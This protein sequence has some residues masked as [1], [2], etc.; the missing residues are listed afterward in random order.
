MEN[1]IE[2]ISRKTKSLD[3]LS[4]YKSRVSK[5]GHSK[6]GEFRVQD[7]GENKDEKKKKKKKKK[8]KIVKEVALDSLEPVVKKIR[9]SL[10]EGHVNDTQSGSVSVDSGLSLSGL[11]QKN[12]LNGLS[13][14]LCLGGPG[15]VIHIPKRPRGSVRRKKV[16]GNGQ[17][18]ISGPSDSVDMA[19]KSNGETRKA[20]FSGSSGGEAGSDD[21][22]AKLLSYSGSNARGSKVKR[23]RIVDKVKDSRNGTS[24]RHA[25]EEGGHVGTSNG[26]TSS[27]KHR[28]NHRKRKDLGSGSETAQKRNVDEVKYS[29][30]DTPSQHAKEEGG[31]V[32]VING[33]SSSKKRRSNDRKRKDLGSGSETAQKT[34]ADEVK[35][36][37]NGT[38]S[39]HAKEECGHVVSNGDSSSRKCRSNHRKKK[40]L[41]SGSET[42]QKR[43]VD[44]VKDSINGTPSRHAKAEGGHVVVNNGD[45]S[46]KKCQSNHMKR[47]DLGLGSETVQKRN[48]DEVKDSSNGTPSQHAKQEG[49]HVVV[50]DGDTS[51]KKRQS[52]HGKRKDL[53]SSLKTAQK[54]VEPS[55]DN[56][57]SV[58]DDFQDDD[59]DEEK[60]EQNAARMLSSRFDPRFT[61]FTSRSRSSGNP[62][63]NAVSSSRSYRQNFVSRREDSLAGLKSKDA[64][65]VLRP[66]RQLKEKGLSRKRRHFYEIVTSNLDAFWFLNRRIKV[67]W[68]LDES[69]YYGR[70][71]DYDP[72]RNL[73]HV[74]YDDWD[75]EW[76]DL[77]KEKFKLLMLP[78]EVPG[79]PEGEKTSTI[80]RYSDK[81][82]TSSE[83][84]DSFDESYLDSEP[85]ISWL[86]RASH[87][88]KSS[89]SSHLKK[90]KTLQLSP[91]V[92]QPV[93]S[94]KTDCTGADVGSFAG[95]GSKS[96]SDST[97]PDKF[98]DGERAENSLLGSPSS[99]KGSP[100]VVYVRRHLRKNSGGLSPVCK[101]DRARRSRRQNFA[102][103][104]IV[105]DSFS[106]KWRKS[107]LGCS[108]NDKL[109]WSIDDQGLLRLRVPVGESVR[110]RLG[111][112][113]PVL[114]FL[115]YSF[116][117]D[118]FGFSHALVLPSYGTIITTWPEVALEMLF[119]DNTIGLR[120]LLFEGCLKLAL[121]LFSLV[122][123]V[124]SQSSGEWK[125]FDMQLPITS[126]QFKF[127]SA[128]NLGKQKEFAFYSFSKLKQSKWVYLDFMLQRYCLR[129]KKFPIS[130]CTY[131]N[132][133]TLE[134][135]S[136]ELHTPYV[137]AG[138]FPVKKRFVQSILPMG[139]SRESSSKLMSQS[140]VNSTL[141]PGKIPAFALSF[142]AAPTFFLSMH[143]Q[144][145]MERNFACINFQDNSS[146]SAFGDSEVDVQTTSV[147]HP[148]VASC[149][150]N[151]IGKIPGCDKQ[152]LLENAASSQLLCSVEYCPGRDVYSEVTD[153]D[154]RKSAQ[155]PD[156][157]KLDITMSSS[158]SKDFE[159]CAADTVVE[160]C[161]HECNNH[162]SEQN[163]E[164]SNPSVSRTV[165]P[166]GL[167]NSKSYSTL[168]AL[169]IELPSSDQN[170][171]LLGQ[172]VNISR[173]VS[174]LAGNTSDGISQSPCP[175]GLT[176]SSLHD[177]NGSNSSPFRDFSPVPH[178][179]SN[180]ISNGF[181]KGPKRPR[182]QVR[183]TL[184]PGGYDSSSK[185]KSQNQRAFLY[186]RIRRSNE[187]R[188]SDDFRGSQKKLELLSCD[189][190]I[191]VTLRDKGWRESG[192]RIFLELTDQNEWR[193]AVKVSGVTKYSYKVNHIL[194]PGS[195]N[196]F[197]HAMMWKGGKDWVL[198]FPD[199]SQWTIF[200]EMH[201][202]CHNRNIRAA[203]VKTIPI[204]GVRLIEESD[205]YVADVLSI[206]H[207]PK[208][209]RQVESDVDMAM[210][211][212]RVLYDMDSDDE[213]WILKN[214]KYLCSDENKPKE[215]SFELFEKM[216]DMLEKF[217]YSQQRDQ[218]T[219]SELEELMV[220]IDSMQLVTGIY[221]HWRQ[222]RQRKGMPLIRHFQPPLWERYQHQVKEWEQA[223]AGCK[224]NTLLNERPLM[225]AFCLKPRG[226]EVPNKGS[227]QRSQRRFPVSGHSQAVSGDL[228]GCHTFGRR[229]NG[230]AVGEEK[231]V[232]SGN[233][234]EFSDSSP[235]LQASTR[236][237]SPR[238]AG[239]LG[240]FSLSSD[241]PEWNHYPKYHRNKPKNG[242]FLSPNSLHLDQYPQRTVGMKNGSHRWNMELPEWPSQK[243]HIY[244]GSRS[245]GME[246]LDGSDLHEFKLRD[247]SGAARHALNMAKLKR[248]RAQRLLYR[249]DLAIHKA[250][251]ALTTAE[252]KKAAFDSCTGDS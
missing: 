150:E 214:G 164:A 102:S 170:G 228:E 29:S 238:D 30:N 215:V 226:L 246:H 198:E 1:S 216:L 186:K 237:F 20:E 95:D 46:S 146:L 155:P 161:E 245:H 141:K 158:H 242:A 63:D 66:R 243:N 64:S 200:K 86:S 14:S 10:G 99:S 211:P 103:S 171:Y 50:S 94:A 70:V 130:E 107:F 97:L 67:Y 4:I 235:S 77:H 222:K 48:V 43:N 88:V 232:F 143:L 12:G 34:N 124:F 160:P 31:P 201:E 193:L 38:P 106:W 18:K 156:F 251:V 199:R 135:G 61:G 137:G 168:G 229:V 113:L 121:K 142:T 129:S 92:V 127:S 15:N 21:R 72:K 147:F 167:S 35:D 179:K 249:A 52:D 83:D 108:E 248:Q 225:F 196:R 157:G 197:T 9:K 149:P 203:S 224:E 73:H 58:F 241:V 152:T 90:Q 187:K 71:N 223:V 134:G 207:S 23:K 244:E 111:V 115:D 112:C 68:P 169:S 252:A 148:E 51:S 69:W 33:N 159:M 173:Q 57:S 109:L 208:Y 236:V 65:R 6:Q 36:S 185:D 44:E 162:E 25:K 133:K 202:E 183:Y 104:D 219:V 128:Q 175:I 166:S 206:Q 2:K 116:L 240:F 227:K 19:G 177:G 100:C 84:D 5:E 190:N 101:S 28:S 140:A 123:T 213:E 209:F 153:V 125:F 16:E 176:S 8:R 247:A 210:D 191:L 32:A 40:D 212:S 230:F 93:L 105:A 54:K 192:A 118:R 163:V 233:S 144:L 189:A 76:I 110:F 96:D 204:P 182:T 122:L 172:G 195:T 138:F 139:V 85:I 82:K 117:A 217:A 56:S 180:L 55:V 11:S 81:R 165:A 239:G 120:F 74:K 39:R 145:L 26:N 53:G 78:S 3:L 132:I 49:G 7:G 194:Q 234:C 231:S 136:Y 250:V 221:G 45:S 22:I 37:S 205:D 24:S 151:A 87:R 80:D 13:F 59:D 218:F 41:G 91:S 119:V 75:E 62:S 47:K 89:P 79:K 27:K 126:M 131:D 178:G 174:D 98:A 181:G 114:Q 220:G 154:S 42:A 188:L 17:A 184:P 60:L